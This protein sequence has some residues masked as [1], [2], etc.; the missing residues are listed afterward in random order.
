MLG[1]PRFDVMSTKTHLTRRDLLR[2]TP[3][4]DLDNPVHIASLLVH[5]TPAACKTLASY[6]HDDR[7]I[8]IHPTPQPG[9][10]AVVLE[11]AD[12]RAIADIASRIQE[13]AGVVS[14]SVVAHVVESERELRQEHIDG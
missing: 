2:L 6:F 14:V 11:S 10:V 8:E 7:G 9:K 3:A 5:A 12:D 4:K 13:I 1:R